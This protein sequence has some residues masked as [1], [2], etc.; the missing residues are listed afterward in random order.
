MV[1]QL[2]YFRDS[3]TNEEGVFFVFLFWVPTIVQ[4]ISRFADLKLQRGG[5]LRKIWVLKIIFVEMTPQER[6]KIDV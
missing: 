4:K 3:E 5:F 2:I 6:V 1:K